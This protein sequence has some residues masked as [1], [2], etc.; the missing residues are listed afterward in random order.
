M[1][2]S[3]FLLFYVLAL[4]FC[5]ACTY[6]CFRILVKLLVTEW[7]PFRKIVANSAHDIFFLCVCFVYYRYLIVNLD[8]LTSVFWSGNFFLIESLPDHCPLLPDTCP[9]YM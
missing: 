4:N 9:L 5:A 1:L 3:W 2:L 7:P 8:F 6:V